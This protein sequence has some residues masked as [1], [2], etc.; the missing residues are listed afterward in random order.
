MF[1]LQCYIFFSKLSNANTIR[2]RGAMSDIGNSH[3]SVKGLRVQG[4]W[5]SYFHS[6]L[7]VNCRSQYVV[8]GER[9]V[10]D[11]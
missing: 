4:Q 6:S 8:F 2:L 10:F 3:G 11:M 9:N 5:E 1:K 7:C